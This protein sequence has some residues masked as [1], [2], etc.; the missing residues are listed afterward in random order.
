VI[1]DLSGDNPVGEYLDYMAEF[2]YGLEN[3][4]KAE[5]N[6]YSVRIPIMN[7]R[8]KMA[9]DAFNMHIYLYLKSKKPQEWWQMKG[10]SVL[11]Q[12]DV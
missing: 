4:N 5:S 10:T 11:I 9:H 3:A 1:K 12:L 7:P 8:F 2:N 6:Y